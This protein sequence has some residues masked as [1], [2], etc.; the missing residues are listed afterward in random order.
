MAF[1]KC[2]NIALSGVSY[3]GIKK[4]KRWKIREKSKNKDLAHLWSYN[5][6]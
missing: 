4:K 3:G 1:Y 6:K 5:T 2:F